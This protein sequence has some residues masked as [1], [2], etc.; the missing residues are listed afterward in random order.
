MND[1]DRKELIRQAS[2]VRERAYAPYSG[3][4][5]GAALLT[6]SGQIFTG[7]NVENASYSATIC[8]ERAAVSAAIA[9]GER[10]FIA[11]AVVTTNGA[12]PCGVCRQVL[13]EFGR[14]TIVLVADTTGAIRQ[15]TTVGALLPDGFGPA[16][17]ASSA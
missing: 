7:C 11:I 10:S 8:A 6:A 16:S 3:Y 12:A 4:A 9:A 15:E 5:V 13:N 17:L 14:R 2:A 1:L